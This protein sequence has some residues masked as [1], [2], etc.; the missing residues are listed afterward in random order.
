[1]QDHGDLVGKS[2][3]VVRRRVG[4][5]NGRVAVV[6][7]LPSEVAIME[8]I[9]GSADAIQSVPGPP[10]PPRAFRFTR[11]QYELMGE[12]GVLAERPR[13][14][15]IFGEIVEMSPQNALHGYAIARLTDI[16]TAAVARKMAVRVQLPL[17]LGLHSEPEPDLC[18]APWP[19]ELRPEHPQW[20]PLVIEVADSSLEYDRTTKLRMY[21]LA[22]V[23]EYW[24][25]DVNGRAIEVYTEPAAGAY[26]SKRT[27]RVGER[28]AAGGVDGLVFLVSE[29]FG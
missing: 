3:R 22:G 17:A 25:V 20:A 7:A 4:G 9:S 26:G 28:V 1:M 23:P 16:L 29:V 12:S 14:E 27:V 18:V 13:V 15:L 24:V 10:S 2:R 5:H 19:T 6:K 11:A 21:A 8:N